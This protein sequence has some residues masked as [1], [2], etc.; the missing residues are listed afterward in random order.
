MRLSLDEFKTIY[1]EAGSLAPWACNSMLPAI[2]TGQRSKD[3]AGMQFR[4]LQGRLFTHPATQ[5]RRK[6]PPVSGVGI[7][8]NRHHRRCRVIVSGYYSIALDG[9]SHHR[10][11]NGHLHPSTISHNF[12]KVR[13]M[14]KLAWEKEPPSFH[15]IRSLAG[16]LYGDNSG[17]DV[18][19]L[20]GHA[21][22]A[23]M[24]MYVDVR[25]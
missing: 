8:W 5:D 7:A 15:E 22:P 4:D 9:A 6:D 19:C 23:T 11:K 2:T 25:D 3:I 18:Q 12:S 10:K 13:N 20:P 21:D 17:M 14:T 16:R 1:Q 24:A